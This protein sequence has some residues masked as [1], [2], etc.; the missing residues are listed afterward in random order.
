[1]ERVWESHL[2]ILNSK[3]EPST[4]QYL[5]STVLD[6]RSEVEFLFL[7]VSNDFLFYDVL[8]SLFSRNKLILQEI[9]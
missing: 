1:M 9:I 5:C 2:K 7:L 8:L 6:A 3:K 4:P